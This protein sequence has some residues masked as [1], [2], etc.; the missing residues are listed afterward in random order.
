MKPS[1]SQSAWDSDWISALLMTAT[2]GRWQTP[3]VK[4]LSCRLAFGRMARHDKVNDL[5]WR[6][7]CKANVPSVKEPSG[8]VRDDGKHHDGSTLIP[9]HAGKS[10][11]WDVTVVN[12][13]AESYMSMSASLGS[14]AQHAAPRK[15]AKIRLCHL[16]TSSNLRL[17]RLL[18]LWT[19]PAL[20][21]YLSWAAD[22]RALQETCMKR[23]IFSS[24]SPWQ[25][26]NTIRWLSRVLFCNHP[27]SHD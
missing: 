26:S 12:M 2:V 16:P 6:A 10:V 8:L 27:H 17:R 14:A 24:G 15:S 23:R 9:W 7:L 20:R 19:Q 4:C 11:A 3:D 18:A 13:L 1:K 21:S 25:S 5:V 22:W